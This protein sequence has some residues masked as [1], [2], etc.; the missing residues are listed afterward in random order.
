MVPMVYT[1]C[2]D[3][4]GVWKGVEGYTVT[5]GTLCFSDVSRHEYQNPIPFVR[6]GL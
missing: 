5:P 1:S 4:G 2:S 3:S 6:K